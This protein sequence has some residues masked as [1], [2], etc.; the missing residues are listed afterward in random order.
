VIKIKRCTRCR[1]FLGEN[2]FIFINKSKGWR[3]SICRKCNSVALV[4]WKESNPN[5]HK[6]W[7]KKNNQHLKKYMSQWRKDNPEYAKRWEKDNPEKRKVQKK[8]WHRANPNYHKNYII[9]NRDKV[10]AQNARHR[11]E[12]INATPI[13]TQSE[14]EKVALY[15]LKAKEMGN[16][17]HVDH[18]QPLSKGGLHHPDNLQI[19]PAYHNQKK[20]NNENYIVPEN[21]II[22]FKQIKAEKK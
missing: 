22:Q 21:L 10:N 1:R 13:L 2:S 14:K 11:A 4:L 20:Y 12:K 3:S 15:Y 7:A 9:N 16:D 19:I 17:W 6:Q 18:I 8:I 5:N